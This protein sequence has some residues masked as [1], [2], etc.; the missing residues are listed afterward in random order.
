M[1][2]PPAPSPP[3]R[4]RLDGFNGLVLAGAIANGLVILCLLGYALMH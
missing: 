3:A 4:S 1:T 2:Q